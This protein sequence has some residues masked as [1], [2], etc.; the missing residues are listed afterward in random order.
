[1]KNNRIWTDFQSQENCALLQIYRKL[2][3]L[4]VFDDA[5]QVFV[6]NYVF[7]FTN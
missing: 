6:E 5:Q 7:I 3:D 2:A 1:M 4:V